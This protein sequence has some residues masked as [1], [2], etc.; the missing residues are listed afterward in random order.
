MAPRTVRV[1]FREPVPPP[2]ASW[3]AF[4]GIVDVSPAQ[5]RLQVR[6][7]LAPVVESLAGLPVGDLDVR[8]PR[9]EDVVIQ[10]YREAP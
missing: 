7:S 10:Y 1:V 4:V 9:L 6:G 3:P 8:E 2:P 5:W